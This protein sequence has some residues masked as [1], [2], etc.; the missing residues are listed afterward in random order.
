MAKTLKLTFG[1]EDTEFTRQY[2]FDVADSLDGDAAKVAILGVNTSLKNNTDDGLSSFF[3]SNEGDDFTL[4][5]AAQL[6]E[7]NKT[8]LDLNIGGDS[9]ASIS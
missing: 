2:N 1:Y 6:E 7:V 8:V 9:A 3:V 4:I 5:T